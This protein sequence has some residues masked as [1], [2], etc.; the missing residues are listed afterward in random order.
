ML[1][2]FAHYT[3][4]IGRL[5]LSTLRGIHRELLG[6]KYHGTLYV[7]LYPYKLIEIDLWYFF[8]MKYPLVCLFLFLFP[9]EELLY[10]GFMTFGHCC[11][12]DQSTSTTL[13]QPSPDL[14]NGCLLWE[15]LRE[16]LNFLLIVCSISSPFYRLYFSTTFI[17]MFS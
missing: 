6:Y 1:R 15:Q 17:N 4:Q 16:I 7:S 9:F 13:Q 14:L 5:S 10:S 12:S 2:R 3:K 11:L 8:H